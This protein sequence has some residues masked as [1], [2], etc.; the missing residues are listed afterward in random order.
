[1]PPAWGARYR[2][3]GRFGFMLLMATFLVPGLWSVLLWPVGVVTTTV[4][5]AI[6]P[7]ALPTIP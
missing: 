3:L 7:F 1:M 2:E 6:D 5:T 4:Y